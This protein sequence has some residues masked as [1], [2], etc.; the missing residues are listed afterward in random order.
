M[1]HI[2]SKIISGMCRL[3]NGIQICTKIIYTSAII[4]VLSKYLILIF[5]FDS[6]SAFF[7]SISGSRW[8]LLGTLGRWCPTILFNSRKN[9]SIYSTISLILSW[10]H[11]MDWKM[12]F[13]FLKSLL[14]MHTLTCICDTFWPNIFGTMV[15]FR[16]VA[17]AYF[18]FQIC[19]LKNY[20]SND[21]A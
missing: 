14:Y 6:H 21:Q 18:Y 17:F 9:S 13:I 15:L 2:F 12:E 3:C 11:E 19:I 7:Y 1:F 16:L 20:H 8:G 5:T 4:N 10:S